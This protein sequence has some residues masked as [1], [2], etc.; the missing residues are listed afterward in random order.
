M[1]HELFNA[2]LEKNALA[3]DTIITANYETTDLFGR[4]FLKTGDFKIKR[5][6]KSN[7]QVCI[8]LIALRDVSNSI[9]KTEVSNI[10]AIDGMNLERF[11]DIY[12]LYLDGSKKKTGRKRGR[13]PKTSLSM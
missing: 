11:A 1:K 4:T 3:S 12:D 9:V 8:E 10:K 2:L 6:L 13:K 7:E 5:V